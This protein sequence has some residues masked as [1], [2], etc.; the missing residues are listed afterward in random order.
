MS[1][2]LVDD[3]EAMAMQ[4]AAD[5]GLVLVRAHNKSG[6]HG[7]SSRKGKQEGQC[8]L[9]RAR[10]NGKDVRVGSYCS[11]AEGALAF[12]RFVGPAECAT[13]ASTARA[14]SGPSKYSGF[15]KPYSATY[16]ET[17]RGEVDAPNLLLECEAVSD[18]DDD[19]AAEHVPIDILGGGKH[20]LALGGNRDAQSGTGV[21][22]APSV[23]SSSS[24]ATHAAPVADAP[25]VL[26]KRKRA[27][28]TDEY[29]VQLEPGTRSLTL[30]VPAGVAHEARRRRCTVSI[31]FSWD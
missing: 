2:T 4:L 3:V 1:V 29:E 13:L 7:V 12:A 25:A 15:G 16:A 14:V 27:M 30:P 8:F 21:S 26:R 20:A 22:G 17:I 11:A 28:R 23:P 24:A 19:T 10:Q 9:V 5:E 18:D 6:F 31:R